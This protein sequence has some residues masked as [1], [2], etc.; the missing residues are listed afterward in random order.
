M[1]APARRHAI[2]LC[3]LAVVAVT[4]AV[5]QPTRHVV[6]VGSSGHVLELALGSVAGALAV[7]VTEAPAWVVFDAPRADAADDD[8]GEAVARLT[9]RVGG[10]VEALS[11]GIVG[12]RVVDATGHVRAT[13]HVF[14]TAGAPAELSLVP[15]RP[16]PARGAATVG[17]ALPEAAAVR[18]SG[19]DALGR[20]VRV[21]ADGTYAAGG[22]EARVDGL[23]AGTYVVRLVAGREARTQRLTVVR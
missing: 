10:A 12:L 16:N 22:A 6:P 9:F 3:G 4:S 18:V 19:F 21:L 17:W 13:H 8:A 14:L 7:V 5:A 1:S 11:E 15:P 2:L 23:S 20:E